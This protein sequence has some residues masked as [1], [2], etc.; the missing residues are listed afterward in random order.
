M[1]WAHTNAQNQGSHRNPGKMEKE[2]YRYPRI[3]QILH[4]DYRNFIHP[5]SYYKRLRV[6]FIDFP[7]LI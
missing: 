7:T 1:P 4:T 5:S 3:T 2:S 6:V